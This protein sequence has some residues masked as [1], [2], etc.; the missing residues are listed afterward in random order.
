MYHEQPYF[1][2]HRGPYTAI[3]TLDKPYEAAGRFVD[4]LS[5][6]LAVLDHPVIAP[7]ACAFL[8]DANQPHGVPHVL[9]VSGRIRACYEGDDKTSFL[10]QAPTQTDG[11]ARIWWAEADPKMSRHIPFLGARWI[12]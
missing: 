11:V 4:L 6:T 7:Q 5:P 2:V 8:T 12:V 1:L 9:A 3:R 10:V